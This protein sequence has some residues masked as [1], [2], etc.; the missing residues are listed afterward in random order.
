DTDQGDAY[1]V[2]I[3]T[4]N[5]KW[6]QEIPR[7]LAHFLLSG[8][9][10][11]PTL[12]QLLPGNLFARLLELS[13]Q[14]PLLPACKVCCARYSVE[15][16]SDRFTLDVGVHTTTA[17]CLPYGVLEYKSARDDA[18]PPGSLLSLLLPPLKLS[19]FLWATGV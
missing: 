13:Q 15:D 12:A 4:E 16:E 8:V 17:K 19:K 1:A 11:T 7:S 9:D 2:S 18:T 14:K 5:E 6:R 3:K 10:P